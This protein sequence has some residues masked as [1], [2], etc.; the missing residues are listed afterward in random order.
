MNGEE[1]TATLD[2]IKGNALWFVQE[3]ESMFD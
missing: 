1:L 3:N 2:M